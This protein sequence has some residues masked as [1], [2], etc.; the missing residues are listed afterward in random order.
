[1]E[2]KF[3]INTITAWNEPHRARHQFTFAASGKYKTVFV[4][5]NKT[6]L[7]RIRISEPEPNITLVEP[8]FPIDYRFRYRLPVINELYQNWLFPKLK[9]IYSEIT[10]INFDFT[11]TQLFKYY[12]DV[13]YYCNDE[14]IGN[15][16]Y[17]SP[18]IDRYIAG[19]ERKVASGAVFC[20]AT[21]NYL[22]NKLKKYNR[23]SYEIPLGVSA[24]KVSAKY[25]RKSGN[26]KIV[27]GFMGVI[28]KRQFSVEAV[29]QIAGDPRFLLVLIGPIERSFVRKLKYK[30]NIRITGV[31]KGGELSKELEKLDVGVALYNLKWVKPGTTPNKLWQYL[32]HG[33]PAVVSNL[34]DLKKMKFPEK[35]VYI[36]NEEKDLAAM[37]D[38]AVSED[39]EELHKLRITFARQNTWND[40]FKQFMLIYNRHFR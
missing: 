40:R 30:D 20:V 8:Y 12:S 17:Q 37:I 5:L 21:A 3:L 1:M 33:K 14:Y 38:R 23:N 16:K 35:S 6:G 4:S 31:L 9:K 19:C 34:P 22:S 27:V 15:S 29:D 26:S 32:S 39:T 28:N 36:L 18:L 2:P 11:A 24:G 7:P 13:V 10:V 25:V